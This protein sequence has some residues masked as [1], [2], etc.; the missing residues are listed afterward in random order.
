[1]NK[2]VIP[3]IKDSSGETLP[4][5]IYFAGSFQKNTSLVVLLHGAGGDH[6]HFDLTVPMLIKAGYAVLTVDLRGHGESQVKNDHDMHVSFESMAND[7]DTVFQWLKDKFGGTTNSR[8]FIGGLSMGGMLAQVCAQTRKVAWHQLGY[9]IV[10]VIAIACPSVNMIW[11]RIPWMDIYRGASS[12]DPNAMEAARKAIV[13]SAVQDNARKETGRAMDLINNTTLFQ[14]LRSCAD[15]LPPPPCTT[16]DP[17]P[18][19]FDTNPLKLPLL[20][21][22]GAQDEHTVKVMHAWQQLNEQHHISSQFTM[23]DNAGHMVSLDT[24]LHLAHAIL[25]FLAQ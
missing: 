8:V 4:L 3:V 1:M 21:V 10:G 7:L 11:P 16:N 6:Y 17:I 22:T 23:I 18:P 25:K 13:G 14:S 9:D 20:L 5:H 15:A 24:G 12:M 2:Y 19:L